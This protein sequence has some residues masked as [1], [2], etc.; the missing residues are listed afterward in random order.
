MDK[1]KTKWYKHP[2]FV[3]TVSLMVG[4]PIGLGVPRPA[5]DVCI[6]ALNEAA[7]AIDTESRMFEASVEFAEALEINDIDGMNYNVE[8]IGYLMSSLETNNFD[9]AATAC[10]NY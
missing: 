5:P 9:A 8:E 1:Q 7:L 6:E 2:L 4:I 10:A 3:T